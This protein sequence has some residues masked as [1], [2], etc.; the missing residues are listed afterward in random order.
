MK[1][2]VSL[3]FALL[4]LM[5]AFV[6][7]HLQAK[8]KNPYSYLPKPPVSLDYVVLPDKEMYD[9]GEIISFEV[10]ATL[11]TIACDP[12]CE[13]RVYFG[14]LSQLLT[15]SELLESTVMNYYI[16]NQDNPVSLISFQVK[17]LSYNKPPF[18]EVKTVR[19]APQDSKAKKQFLNVVIDQFSKSY[20]TSQAY[21]KVR[22]SGYGDTGY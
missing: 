15:Q 10:L 22:N 7:N 4:I 18:L 2:Y 1:V 6:P 3:L 12:F 17:M 8:E 21:A 14:N 9:N 19:I 16:L 13:Y 11:D 20:I 5:V